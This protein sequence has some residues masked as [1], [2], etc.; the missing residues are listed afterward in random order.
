MIPQFLARVVRSTI[1]AGGALA[2]LQATPSPAAVLAEGTYTITAPEQR[3]VPF[4]MIL[5][6]SGARI[7][8]GRG[9]TLVFSY[10]KKTAL[11]I[12]AASRSYFMLPLELVP[13]L[14]AAGIGYDPRGLG[15]T[16]SGATKTLLGR[17]CSEVVVNGNA[18]R[19]TLRSY[20]LA[21]P[22]WSRDYARL[23]RAVGLPW[24]GAD[25]PAVFVGLPLSG[26]IDVEGARPY[27]ASWEI[28]RLSRDD[29]AGENF[30]V[31]A[32][33]RMDLERLLSLQ[34]TGGR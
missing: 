32:G 12:D 25:P 15:A 14:L 20:R 29:Q 19:F 27:R 24:V 33:Y 28:T 30:T 22:E 4:S 34:G 5:T 11:I 1:A 16:A 26:R 7:T 13:P 9:E 8:P 31:P 10:E 18:P 2:L 21:D 3:T 23:E 17:S 6:P